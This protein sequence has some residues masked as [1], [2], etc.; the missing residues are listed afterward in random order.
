[1]ASIIV[2]GGKGFIGKPLVQRLRNVGH[3]VIALDRGHGDLADGRAWS[4]LPAAT[5]VFHLAGRS[6]VPDAWSDQAG[7][8]TTNVAA[9][10]HALEYCRRYSAHL[11]F[12]SA[13]VYGIPVYLP[14]DEKHPVSPNNPYALSKVLAERACRFY[15]DTFGM[16]VTILRP[17]NVFGPGQR[18]EF[19][20]PTILEQVANGNEIRV[21]T[22]APRRDYVLVD[23]VVSALLQTLANP[24]GYRILNIGSG[25][26]YSV[27]EIVDMV[28]AIAGTHL[29]VIDEGIDRP[30]EIPDV[31]ANISRAREQLDWKPSC[32]F[33]EGIALTLRAERQRMEA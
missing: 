17:F 7:F 23:D 21:K 10:T 1:M 11:V 28:Q 27:A 13:Y 33:A 30:N 19:L 4:S 24:K 18:R 16:P 5:H 15:M 12:V 32:S 20:L 22:L 9:T 3:D 29:D 6:F 31:R 2:T 26:S 25:E 8:I 14:I